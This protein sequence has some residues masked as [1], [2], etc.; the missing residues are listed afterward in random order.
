MQVVLEHGDQLV[1]DLDVG[2]TPSQAG[3]MRLVEAVAQCVQGAGLT[4]VDQRPRRHRH[5]RL[6]QVA[7]DLAFAAVFKRAD[8]SV[9]NAGWLARA[10]VVG[11]A[12][13]MTRKPDPSD[14]IVRVTQGAADFGQ[15]ATFGVHDQDRPAG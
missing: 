3:E 1:P 13:G 4:T 2:D 9:A 6:R 7:V 11:P 14:Q 10:Q 8:E 5:Q 15:S 12:V